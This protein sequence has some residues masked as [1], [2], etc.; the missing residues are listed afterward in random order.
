MSANDRPTPRERP[1]PAPDSGEDPADLPTIPNRAQPTSEPAATA[2][3]PLAWNAF[4]MQSAGPTKQLGQRVSKPVYD[5]LSDVHESTGI[6]MRALIEYA[7]TQT[8]GTEEGKKLWQE[9]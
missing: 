7:I 8:Y 3:T 9:K 2:A 6:K 5:L 1:R 4:K